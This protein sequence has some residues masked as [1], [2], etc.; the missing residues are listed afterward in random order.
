M[1]CVLTCGHNPDDERIYQKQIRT[2]LDAGYKV[3]YLTKNSTTTPLTDKNLIHKT[4]QLPLRQFIKSCFN[5]IKNAEIQSVHIHEFELLSLAKQVKNHL[6][7]PTIYDVHES[8]IEMWDAFSSKPKLLKKLINFTLWRYEILHLKFVD[9][10]L[11][12]TPN[13]AERYK[14]LGVSAKFVPN[15]PIV[16]KENS[17]S[18]TDSSTIVYHGQISE[19]R[20]IFELLQAMQLV[21]KTHPDAVLNCYGSERKAGTINKFKQNIIQMGLG[22]SVVF[23]SHVVHSEILEILKNSRIGIIPF[24]DNQFTRAGLP[25]KLFEYF[26]CGCAV[27]ASDLPLVRQFGKTA[28]SLVEPENFEGMASQI[29]LLLSDQKRYAKQVGNGFELVSDHY[30]WAKYESKFL[31]VYAD[32]LK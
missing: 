13:L 12:V 21:I 1:I 8:N 32:L 26:L 23:H 15:F 9:F 10:V 6:K 24:R 3:L 30:N 25:V 27:V 11:T 19:E 28:V 22:K 18:K 31:Q 7:L 29:T 4:I 14:K 16:S 5:E 2:L 17:T 20:G